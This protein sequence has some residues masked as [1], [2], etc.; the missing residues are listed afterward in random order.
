MRVQTT[1]A[2]VAVACGVGLS[3]P[4]AGGGWD[5]GNDG[6]VYIHHYPNYPVRFVRDFRVRRLGPRYLHVY[7]IAYPFR[8]M[9][10]TYAYARYRY[11][12]NWRG[13]HGHW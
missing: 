5:D 3:Q 10:P 11:L 13:E 7:H 2:A 6:T 9:G 4:A 8:G 12:Y 1:I